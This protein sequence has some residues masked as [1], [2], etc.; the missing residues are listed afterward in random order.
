MSESSDITLNNSTIFNSDIGIRSSMSSIIILDSS[1]VSTD[2]PIVAVRS[3]IIIPER[4]KPIL[5]VESV[6]TFTT[7]SASSILRIRELDNI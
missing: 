5:V 7:T 4:S 2:Y 6:T 1:F 3:D